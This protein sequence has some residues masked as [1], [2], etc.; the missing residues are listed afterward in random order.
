MVSCWHRQPCTLS[1]TGG[2]WEQ[3]KQLLVT[4]GTGITDANSRQRNRIEKSSGLRF[5]WGPDF[6]KWQVVFQSETDWTLAL[7]VHTVRFWE[8][9]AFQKNAAAYWPAAGT[10]SFLACWP[11][12]TGGSLTPC[13]CAALALQASK[14][15]E[16]WMLCSDIK[17]CCLIKIDWKHSSE[18]KLCCWK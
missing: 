6:V 2:L 1:V 18:S 5:L 11:K 15:K 12:G 3:V 8:H 17:Y 14:E 16:A 10:A 9:I 4:S 13:L 7:I